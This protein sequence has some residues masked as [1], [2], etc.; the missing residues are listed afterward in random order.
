MA[1][2]MA[3]LGMV[4]ASDEDGSSLSFNSG[5][6]VWQGLGVLFPRGG[7]PGLVYDLSRVFSTKS[8]SSRFSLPWRL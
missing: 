6:T 4:D 1:L 8:L 3:P 7:L 5:D 2:G